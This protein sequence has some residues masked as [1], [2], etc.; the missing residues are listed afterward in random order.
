MI[1]RSCSMI[2]RTK[3]SRQNRRSRRRQKSSHI[4]RI[5]DDSTC[6]RR[7]NPESGTGQQSPRRPGLGPEPPQLLS[8]ARKV[9]D[10]IDRRTRSAWL[11]VTIAR[12]TVTSQAV[13]PI[14]RRPRFVEQPAPAA[15]LADRESAS[16]LRGFARS[17]IDAAGA[18]SHTRSK[19]C[20]IG[21]GQEGLLAFVA[22]R[23]G[24]KNDE[25]RSHSVVPFLRRSYLPGSSVARHGPRHS[26]RRRTQGSCAES[27]RHTNCKQLCDIAG[28]HQR[29]HPL[30]GIGGAME[31]FVR[32]ALADDDPDIRESLQ[33]ML[34]E[35]GHEVVAAAENGE[36][37][38]RL[39][40]L[41]KP[42]VVITG[43]LTPDLYGSDA[44]AAVYE[45]GR[46]RSFSTRAIASPI[47]CA[48]RSTSTYSCIS[49]S[50]S[51]RKLCRRR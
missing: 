13:L 23:T 43:T 14:G 18:E 40:A 5:E 22:S 45:A 9:R 11:K 17:K 6:P 28:R 8:V 31:F 44:A 4:G 36:S 49:S 21:H 24:E 41:A 2:C 47:W 27:I 51:A 29:H 50:R 26:A 19:L 1:T 33:Q 10:S 12:K 39:C 25:R 3:S 42:D 34:R 46:S 32:V 30:N 38:I 20:A 16:R 7:R 35:L 15:L 48:M 37:L